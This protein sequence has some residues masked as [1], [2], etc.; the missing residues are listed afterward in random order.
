MTA[1]RVAQQQPGPLHVD[2][3]VLVSRLPRTH[4]RH[5]LFRTTQSMSNTPYII[6]PPHN[7]DGILT[8]SHGA[9]FPCYCTLLSTWLCPCRVVTNCIPTQMLAQTAPLHV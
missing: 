4:V 6:G 8:P 1:L 3:L 2:S 5:D 7:H 9:T